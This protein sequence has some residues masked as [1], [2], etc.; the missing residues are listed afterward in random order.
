MVLSNP[1]TSS[2]DSSLEGSCFLLF[3]CRKIIEGQFPCG[4]Q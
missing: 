2:M 3:C 1:S 4:R